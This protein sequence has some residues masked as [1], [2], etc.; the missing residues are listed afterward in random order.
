MTIAVVKLVT[1]SD[2]FSDKYYDAQSVR[3]ENKTYCCRQ[4]LGV[5]SIESLKLHFITDKS[6]HNPHCW[7]IRHRQNVLRA[8]VVRTEVDVAN[9]VILRR[10]P[11]FEAH[12]S[13]EWNTFWA[14]KARDTALLMHLSLHG[15][16][17]KNRRRLQVFFNED[18]NGN[19]RCKL[20]LRVICELV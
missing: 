1:L 8:L 15:L 5:L 9:H 13:T 18:Q 11:I 16:H 20:S 7:R 2:T 12:R 3:C 10:L 4:S 14:S 17:W 19:P 6:I